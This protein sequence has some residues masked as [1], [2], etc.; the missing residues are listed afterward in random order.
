MSAEEGD[1]RIRSV[2]TLAVAEQE[3]VVPPDPR[4][5]RWSPPP[6]TVPRRVAHAIDTLE[7]ICP[8]ADC[9]SCKMRGFD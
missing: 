3:F 7:I 6:F 4:S 2:V 9:T 5:I 1:L 8:N